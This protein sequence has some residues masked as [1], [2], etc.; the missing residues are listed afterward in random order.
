VGAGDGERKVGVHVGVTFG[1]LVAR[2]VGTNVAVSSG[3]I[4]GNGVSIGEGGGVSIG[5]ACVGSGESGGESKGES[6]GDEAADS[7]S[8]AKKTI[9]IQAARTPTSATRG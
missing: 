6:S 2:C 1:S 4:E 7:E 8:C 3:V 9:A 5:E